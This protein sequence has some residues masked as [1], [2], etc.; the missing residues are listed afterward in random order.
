MAKAKQ[1]PSGK[2]RVR[3]FSHTDK[4]GKKVVVSFTADTKKEAELLAAQY[5]VTKTTEEKPQMLTLGEAMDK[6]IDMKSNIL[7]PPTLK[8]YRSIR[9]NHFKSIIDI[10][11]SKITG[12][13]IQR[14]VNNEIMNHSPKTVK[15]EY[16]F[17]T[18]VLGVFVPK[19]Q[20]KTSLPQQIKK[21]NNIPDNASIVKLI[22]FA[23]NTDI[24]IPILLASMLSLRRSEVCALT[25]GDID[26]K[27]NTV[28]IDKALVLKEYIDNDKVKINWVLK[29]PKTFSS[30]R[31]IAMP[32]ELANI[33]HKYKGVHKENE[34]VVN[35]TPDM[36]TYRFSQIIKKNNL[37]CFRFHDL[38]HYNA[39]VMLTVMPDKYAMQ[40]GGWSNTS[41]L[42]N[43]YQHTFDSEKNLYDT[44][45]NKQFDELLIKTFMPVQKNS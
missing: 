41:T 33:L 27:N 5:A 13:S 38:R 45:L 42:K 15:N 20:L 6:Y 3:A 37:G 39:S 24:Y 10:P 36:V 34:R 2:W 21:Q 28:T 17:L 32:K 26:F 9:K 29:P 7:S 1:L 12:I 8:S 4:N 19:L 40:R 25:W 18:A 11:L 31:T 16:G 14:A 23:E 22:E 44:L 30:N 43:R 35:L